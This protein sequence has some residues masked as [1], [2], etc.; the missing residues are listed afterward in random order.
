MAR[1]KKGTGKQVKTKQNPHD[2]AGNGGNGRPLTRDDNEHTGGLTDEQRQALW[3]RDHKPKLVALR[4]ALATA[5]ADLRNQYKKLKADLGFTRK[6][7]EFALSLDAEDDRALET[8]RRQMMLA[9]W[10]RH[11]IGMQGELFEGRPPE[12]TLDSVF[13]DGKK[14]GLSGLK[15]EPPHDAGSVHGQ[16][17]IAGWHDG[18]A[19]LAKGG[20]KPL[21]EGWDNAASMPAAAQEGTDL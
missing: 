4:K 19:A 10:E 9:R 14:A 2:E 21:D 16:K 20:I 18:Q 1:S 6:D 7:A 17:W 15:C 13:N 12:S 5:T 11:P 8:H 3:F